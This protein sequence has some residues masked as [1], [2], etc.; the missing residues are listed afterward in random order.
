M[1]KKNVKN[2]KKEV[3]KEEI[4]EEV[5]KEEISEETKLWI[6][7]IEEKCRQKTMEKK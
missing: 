4:S 6:E 1:R 7:K 3:P 2:K 5:P